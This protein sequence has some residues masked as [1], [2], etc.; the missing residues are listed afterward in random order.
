MHK[1]IYDIILVVPIGPGNNTEF[2]IDTID[3][4]IHY[5]EQIYKVI[6]LDDSGENVGTKIANLFPHYDLIHTTKQLGG[7][8]GLYITLSMAYKYA[9]EK[10]RFTALLKLDTDALVIGKAFEKEAIS[11]FRSMP[12]AGIA[13]QYP[14]EYDGSPWNLK[15]PE[16][17][18]LN[19]TRSWKFFRRPIANW[20][21]ITLYRNAIR[22]GY[23]TGE[24]VFGGAYFISE[25]LLICLSESGL[26]PRHSFKNLNLGEDHLFSL[27]AKAT[28]FSLESLS[29]NNAPMACAWKG[30]PAS[31][32][33][34]LKEH[35]KIIHSVRSWE[36]MNEQQIRAF[37]KAERKDPL[38]EQNSV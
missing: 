1:Y 21:L 13:G 16:K 18:I 24:S 36:S 20:S 5:S 15:W 10:Y 2:V 25:A 28:G 12:F 4:F 30:L 19:S 38:P 3:S 29:M 35:K 22:N 26:L 31:P 17:R 23:R 9:I 27:L 37:Y 32:E 11:L 14:L 8:A 7:W 34:L 6:L 33:Q